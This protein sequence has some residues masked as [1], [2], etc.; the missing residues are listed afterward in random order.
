[1]K[2]FLTGLICFVCGSYFGIIVMCI[3]Q[4]GK[5]HDIKMEEMIKERIN[6]EQNE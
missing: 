1:M 5:A 4:L 3:F 2:L 6:D